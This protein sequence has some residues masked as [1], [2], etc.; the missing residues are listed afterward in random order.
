MVRNPILDDDRLDLFI[1]KK[2]ALKMLKHCRDFREARLEVMGFMVGH[3]YEWDGDEYT[4]VEDVVTSDLDTSSVSVKFANFEPL[5]GELDGFEKRGKD[6]ILVGWYHSHPGH[7]SFMSGTDKQ[8]QLRMF[9]KEYQSAVVIDPIRMEMKAFKLLDEEVYEKPYGILEGPDSLGDVVF[10]AADDAEEMVE[11]EMVED[12]MLEDWE[13]T[14]DDDGIWE[15][16]EEGGGEDEDGYV[17]GGGRMEEEEEEEEEDYFDYGVAVAHYPRRTREERGNRSTRSIA[18]YTP[19]TNAKSEPISQEEIPS[20]HP[21]EKEL[22]AFDYAWF[23]APVLLGLLGG[24][25]GFLAVRGRKKDPG[26]WMLI[27]GA[28]FSLIWF[29]GGYGY[30]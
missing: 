28:M 17:D 7:T 15:E 23:A 16:E 19:Q 3:R 8:T 12:E 24:I 9:N 6:Y 2:A 1:R 5:F 4:I 30:Y 14:G 20:E 13:D 29:A 10:E 21:E 18:P 27:L 25:F 26:K 11:E 22:D